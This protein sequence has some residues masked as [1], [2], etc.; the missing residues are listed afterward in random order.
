MFTNIHLKNKWKDRLKDVK[1]TRQKQR[2]E[3]KANKKKKQ[4]ENYIDEKN[5]LK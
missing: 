5:R 4:R 3:E 1:M 2:H